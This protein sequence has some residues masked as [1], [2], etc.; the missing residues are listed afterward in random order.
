MPVP[1]VAQPVLVKTPQ[2]YKF[3]YE[4]KDDEGVQY[5]H[6][7][8]DGDGV[9]V[10]GYG[11]S[12]IRGIQRQVEYVADDAG[13]RARIKTNEPGTANQN[14]AA[15][16]LISDAPYAGEIAAL[17]GAK[18]GYAGSHGGVR[19]VVSVAPVRPVVHVARRPVVPVAPIAAHPVVP[20]AAHRPVV[21]VAPVAVN[22]IVPVDVRPVVPVA[23]IVHVR[24]VAVGPVK[25]A[26]S[27]YG[28][29]GAYRRETAPRHT[30]GYGYGYGL[31][32]ID[33]VIVEEIVREY[34]DG[35]LPLEKYLEL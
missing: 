5:R 4:I 8:S 29:R 25:H 26:R 11:F 18:L 28:R 16:E 31:D 32:D 10:G 19:P 23:P 24:P 33:D 7:N 34:G 17:G 6:E 9:V 2:P 3:G 22:P 15:V 13:F 27:G 30:S 21:P 12:D 20:V 14:P 1:V 35:T